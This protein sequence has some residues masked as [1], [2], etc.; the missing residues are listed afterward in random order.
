M[1]TLLIRV[2]STSAS[3]QE[4]MIFFSNCCATGRVPRVQLRSQGDHASASMERT[5]WE[6][7]NASLNQCLMPITAATNIEA[8]NMQQERK[9]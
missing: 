3:V 1:G 5:G 6:E 4:T 7:G 9:V 8:E 2:I